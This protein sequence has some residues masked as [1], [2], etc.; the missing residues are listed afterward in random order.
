MDTGTPSGQAALFDTSSE[1][2]SPVHVTDGPLARRARKGP[3]RIVEIL[4]GS[5]PRESCLRH[6]AGDPHVL[7]RTPGVHRRGT[8]R[9]LD[10]Y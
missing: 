10:R 6:Q 9:D 3:Q 7:G 8:D 1:P 4:C 5:L 2:V